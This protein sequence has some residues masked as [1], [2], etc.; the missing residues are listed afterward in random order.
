MADKKEGHPDAKE[1]K[2]TAAG[3][4]GTAGD[5]APA[6]EGQGEELWG[7]IDQLGS[8]VAKGFDL[9]EAGIGLGINLANRLSSS[10]QVGTGDQLEGVRPLYPG[11]PPAPHGGPSMAEPAQYPHGEW[12]PG[13]AEAPP[14]VNYVVNRLPLFPGSPVQISFTINN[15]SVSSPK[16]L[17]LSVEGFVGEVHG[18]TLN[19]NDFSVE[20]ATKVI[21]PMDFDK[22]TLQGA[23]PPEAPSDAY[24]G[25]I[26][27]AAEEQ[28]RI[29]VRLV[30]S[31]LGWAGDRGE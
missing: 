8:I 12:R 9:I 10:L 21:A 26:V 1:G 18:G 31:D 29:P 28:L 24:G 13:G 17:R 3:R 20:P 19:G 23:I 16:E 11:Q 7:R 6:A 30:V 15:D 4:T 2:R 5:A 27:V 22:F 25:W 14:A